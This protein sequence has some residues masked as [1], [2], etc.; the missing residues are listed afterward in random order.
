MSFGSRK[1]RQSPSPWHNHMVDPIPRT[2]TKWLPLSSCDRANDSQYQHIVALGNGSWGNIRIKLAASTE[3]LLQHLCQISK[4]RRTNISAVMI[5]EYNTSKVCSDC[6]HRMKNVEDRPGAGGHKER[7]HALVKCDHCSTVWNK[8]VNGARN[9]RNLFIYMAM[10]GNE[11]PIAF[12]DQPL[13][14]QPMPKTSPWEGEA[15]IL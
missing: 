3:R 2:K 8:D 13:Q 1:Y 14:H 4:L 6:R 12:V 10:N 9:M 5:D 15:S 7:I 11:R